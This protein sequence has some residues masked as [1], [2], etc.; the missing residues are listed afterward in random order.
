LI[1]SDVDKYRYAHLLVGRGTIV[2][3]GMIVLTDSELSHDVAESV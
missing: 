1:L 2:D 3:G